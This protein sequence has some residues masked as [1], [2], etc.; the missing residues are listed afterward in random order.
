MSLKD[1]VAKMRGKPDSKVKLVILRESEK[2]S[3][4]VT[5][6]RAVIK[7]KP[8][9]SKLLES[10]IGYLRITSFNDYTDTSLQD[11][12]SD[13]E[14]DNKGPLQGVIL[15]LR[16]NPGGLLT[17]AISVSDDF[18]DEGEIV[19]TRGRIAGQD[20]RYTARDGDVLKGKPMV[21]LINGGS[22][23]A[24]EIVAGALQ[25]NK[26]AVML[27]PRVLARAACR[28]SSICRAVLACV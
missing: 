11:H 3:F 22:A 21:V 19:S 23:S 18:L 5:L 26:R 24:A 8:V 17:Q 13:L 6:T 12:L 1:A 25:D 2:R 14:K 7:V 9:K 15:D 28:P 16:N 27:G 4:P 20:A 10:G